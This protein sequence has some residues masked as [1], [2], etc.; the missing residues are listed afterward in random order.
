[1]TSSDLS[2]LDLD[3]VENRLF[4]KYEVTRSDAQLA[5]QYLR[6]FFDLKRER[7]NEL[8]ILPQIADWAWHELILDTIQYRA[9]CQQVFGGFLH[10]IKE[11]IDP[12]EPPLAANS[13]TTPRTNPN[14][15]RDRFEVSLELMQQIYGLGLG[16]R[17]DEWLEAGWDRPA[18]RLRQPVPACHHADE[19]D[20][21]FG[22][23]DM[24]DRNRS[25]FLAWLPDRIASRFGIP[26]RAAS[27]GVQQ[28]ATL[29][30]NAASTVTRNLPR[31]LPILCQIA[32]QE[33]IL[34]TRRYEADCSRVFGR[35]VD[36]APPTERFSIV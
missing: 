6:C 18:Y 1:M 30:L 14:A 10:H 8:I 21:D 22:A 26:A 25:S 36:H 20:V 16:E 7:P 33:H 3:E 11:T 2:R 5:V 35:F 9:I 19:G 17:P 32:W 24:A 23:D 13:C 29:F 31:N 27:R 28:Y 12:D 15:L 34:W 4:S